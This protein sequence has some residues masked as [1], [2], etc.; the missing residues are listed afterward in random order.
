MIAPGEQAVIGGHGRARQPIADL[1]AGVLRALDGAAV[2]L[3]QA[4]AR[5]GPGPVEVYAENNPYGAP[6]DGVRKVQH[7]QPVVIGGS[8]YPDRIEYSFG[9]QFA[10]V[11]VH[12]HTREI[13]VPRL[14]GI[15]AVGCIINPR[16]T[17]SQLMGGMIWELGAA[18]LEQTKIDPRSARYVNAN[19]AEYLIAVNADAPAVEVIIVPEQDR[20]ANQLG[21]KGVGELGIV[22][23]NAAITNA[24]FHA[25]GRRVRELPIRTED[26]L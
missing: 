15:F 6:P 23:V 12:A 16:T 11:R 17:R 3:P 21:M 22:G 4:I 20:D 14:L 7:G 13:R 25:T 8:Q 26:L 5:L 2:P 18:L 10:E 24:V 19:I 9:A 1:L